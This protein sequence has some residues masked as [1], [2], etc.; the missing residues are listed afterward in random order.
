MQALKHELKKLIPLTIFFFLSFGYLL[1]IL[2]LFLK[3]YSI[4]FGV[5]SK[6]LLGAII[7]AKTVAILDAVM[8]SDRFRDSPR[9]VTVL[10]RTF[11]YTLLALAILFIESFIEDYRGTRA[12]SEAIA[13]FLQTEKFSRV[14]ATT[15]LTA[16]VF[17]IHNLWREIDTYLGKGELARF[18]LSR[19]DRST[20]NSHR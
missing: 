18:F 3:D 9:Y 4:D 10:Y 11:V 8:K 15:L 20:P 19:P 17:F 5:I 6:A 12:L 16:I 2:K 7:A 14:L 13:R 1:L